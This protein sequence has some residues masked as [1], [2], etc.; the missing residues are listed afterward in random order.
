MKTKVTFIN[1]ENLFRFHGN[2]KPNFA[3]NF[4]HSESKS[5]YTIFHLNSE[6]KKLFQNIK[7]KP[8]EY[9]F[10]CETERSAYFKTYF[11]VKINIEKNLVY[12]NT[13]EN[14][15]EEIKF[16]SKGVKLIWVNYYLI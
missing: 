13:E 12:F 10:K 15:S 7:L 3:G 5:D 11:F 14:N 8:E 16:S 2:S 6:E 1:N 9:I 4:A